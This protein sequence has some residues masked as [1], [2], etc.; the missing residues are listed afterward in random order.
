MLELTEIFKSVQGESTYMGLPCVFV[1]L[2]GCNLRCV[3]CDTAYAFQGGKKLSIDKILEEI[4]SHGI[5]LVEITG[6]EP[7]MQKEVFPLMD[8]LLKNNFRV[9]LET[10][11]S[12]SIKDVPAEVIKIIDLKCPGSGEKEKNHWDNLNHLASTDEIKFVITDR[13]DYEWSRSTLEK[14]ELDKKSHILFSPV[15]DKLP[16]KDLTEWILEDNLPVRL[17]TQLHKHIWDKNAQGV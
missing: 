9:M 10:G 15:F 16:L 8:T 17:Q 14:Y 2:T 1:R 3:W 11:G 12:L 5:D 13:A 6:G 4:K 7:L